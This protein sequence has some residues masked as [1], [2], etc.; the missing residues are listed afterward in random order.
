MCHFL[1]IGFETE[2]VFNFTLLFFVITLLSIIAIFYLNSIL[3]VKKSN[4]SIPK[5]YIIF[6]AY[7]INEFISKEIYVLLR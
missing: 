2:K 3:F 1:N 6:I 4:Y 7:C 5:F